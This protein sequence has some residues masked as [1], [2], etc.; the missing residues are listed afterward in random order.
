MPIKEEK[1]RGGVIYYRTIKTGKGYRHIG[2]VRKA[3]KKGGRTV[4]G[5][6]YHYKN[7]KKRV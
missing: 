1:K 3:G 5:K 6:E 7:N 4:A 2:I